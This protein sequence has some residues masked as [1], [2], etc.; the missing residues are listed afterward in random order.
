MPRETPLKP[1]TRPR[2]RRRGCLPLVAQRFSGS[3]VE[4]C[5]AAAQPWPGRAPGRLFPAEPAWLHRPAALNKR[6]GLQV[7]WLF[8]ILFFFFFSENNCKPLFRE[9]FFSLLPP[10]GPP[11]H[12]LLPLASDWHASRTEELPPAFSIIYLF[13]YLISLYFHCTFRLQLPKLFDLPRCLLTR[14]KTQA[15]S[16]GSSAHTWAPWRASML[17]PNLVT[18]RARGGNRGGMKGAAG[19]ASKAPPPRPTPALP[20]YRGRRRRTPLRTRE[21]P[22]S[23]APLTAPGGVA[24]GTPGPPSQLP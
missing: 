17:L 22:V 3:T 4:F 20:L 7:R 1:R 24:I 11:D 14:K 6:L 12:Y 8:F 18:Q 19:G 9:N 23:P 2:G 5:P 13:I 15:L 10:S 21:C 16:A